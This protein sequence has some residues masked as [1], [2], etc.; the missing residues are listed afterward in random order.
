[1]NSI[2]FSAL[3][4][5]I[6]VALYYWWS[7]L[8]ALVT[9]SLE[10]V[11]LFYF[12][13]KPKDW[14][15]C[16]FIYLLMILWA[17]TH[18]TQAIQQQI[19]LS[20]Q[21]QTV[22]L[23][24]TIDSL[25]TADLQKRQFILQLQQICFKQ[26]CQQQS[27]RVELTEY[28]S[29]KKSVSETF[30]PADT[31]QLSAR[32]KRKHRLANPGLLRPLDWSQ[33][34]YAVGTIVA[35]PAKQIQTH[36]RFWHMNSLRQM[37][38]TKLQAATIDEDSRGVILA[39]TLG[40]R[41]QLSSHLWQLFQQTGVLHLMAISGLHVGLLVMFA[42]GVITFLLWPFPNLFLY[43]PRQKIALW[44][45]LWVAWLYG[46]IAGFGVSTIR[47]CVMLTL[48]ALAK[49]M[50]RSISWLSVLLWSSCLI[51]LVDPLQSVSISFWL[52]FIAVAC[53]AFLVWIKQNANKG[54]AHSLWIQITLSACLLPFS[55][56]FFQ[57]SPL[58]AP[59]SNLI[60]VP[61]V[62]FIILPL[63][64]IV[65]IV[66]SISST[67]A[68]F[69]FIF[70]HW[71]ITYL[72]IFLQ[73]MV[74]LFPYQWWLQDSATASLFFL[75]NG[76]FL[77]LFPRAWQVKTIAVLWI[78]IA[79]SMPYLIPNQDLVHV[80]V[81]DVGQGLSVV[82][83]T[84]HH[85]LLYDTGPAY[86]GGGDA[87]TLAVVPFLKRQ[88]YPVL[89]MLLV[90]HQDADHSG[91]VPTILKQIPIQQLMTS[92]SRSPFVKKI[93]ANSVFKQQALLNSKQPLQL[94]T[95]VTGQVWQWDGVTFHILSPKAEASS[96][97][98]N[99]LSC[100]LQIQAGQT[101]FLLTGDIEQ[102]VE[103]GLITADGANLA[104]TILIAPHHGSQTSSS[105]AFIQQVSPKIVVFSTG[106][107]N[108][109]HFPAKDVQKRYQLQGVLAYN[110][111]DNGAVSFVV[112]ADGVL[113]PVKSVRKENEH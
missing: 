98:S 26:Q 85:T 28:L 109:Y 113:G 11:T 90:S 111:A 56:L 38:L 105:L 3:A 100:V 95:C 43:W 63:S 54:Y 62:S 10:I 9:I 1:M 33:G 106:Y 36:Q 57:R 18:F 71:H 35:K 110:T 84:K 45:S 34:L 77:L 89:D 76:I 30:Q 65:I 92:P 78:G 41:S 112:T 64:L 97:K 87:A 59:L 69:I 42:Y 86:Y 96:R 70:L 91:G 15:L 24:G 73:K 94:M 19:P 81:L 13:T 22:E 23:T 68:H 39:L 48:Y 31:W 37:V 67:L 104:S 6:T 103:Q 46:A 74:A 21:N 107:L 8:A 40:D 2:L 101:R 5:F 55:L 75:M 44:V 53:I 52:S 72:L 32:L 7:P 47:A 12:I 88:P 83:Q 80:T 82:I 79:C 17:I 50:S 108:R 61:W 4:A 49:S 14:L 27:G 20:W 51:L 102:G 60:A 25:V 16:L 99:N 58:N 66:Q 93:Y 29:K